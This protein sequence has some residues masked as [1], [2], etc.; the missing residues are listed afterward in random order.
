MKRTTFA[1]VG[2][3]LIG[4]SLAA[5]IRRRFSSDRVIG[6]SRDSKKIKLAKKKGFIHEGFSDLARA[7]STADL[8]F[9]CSPVD[10]IPHL[11]SKIDRYA[12]KGAVVTDVGSTKKTIVHWAACKHFRKIEFVGSHPLA[13]SHLTGMEHAKANLFQGAFVFVTP[14]GRSSRQPTR[15][16]SSFWKKVGAQVQIITPT[17]HD[18]IVS[19]ISHLPHIIASILVHVVSGKSLRYA[20]SG[21]LDTTRV[22]Q[23]DPRLWVPIFITNDK[24]LI[25]DLTHFSNSLY[26]FISFLKRGSSRSIQNFLKLAARKRSKIVQSA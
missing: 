1:I 2:L 15:I 24:N 9:V 17:A 23:G 18:K 22:A 13:G 8:I 7:V 11:I 19:E 20:A 26:K 16:I 10:T 25:M 3:G 5:S 12:K 6:F 14:F 21:F 4:S